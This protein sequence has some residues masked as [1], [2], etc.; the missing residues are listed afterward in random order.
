MYLIQNFLLP[1]EAEE[2][3]NYLDE[4]T[5]E[6]NN[7]TKKMLVETDDKFP[8][9]TRTL[10]PKMGVPPDRFPALVERAASIFAMPISHTEILLANINLEAVVPM[11][12]SDTVA[13]GSKD[14]AKE[15]GGQ[16]LMSLLLY[17]NDVPQEYGGTTAFPY[18]G[19]NFQPKKGAALCWYNVLANGKLD[20]FTIHRGLAVTAPGFTKYYIVFFFREFPVLKKV[21]RVKDLMMH[22]E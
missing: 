11:T 16:R 19:L 9:V 6:G 4:Q 15:C 18:L 17:L 22:K 3:I 14:A 8:T 5:K 7:P 2:L 21:N 13:W 20:P 12:H 10:F 1:G